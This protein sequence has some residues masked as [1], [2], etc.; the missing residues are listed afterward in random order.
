MTIERLPL[1]N[2]LAETDERVLP[3]A[4][5]LE[6]HQSQ[7]DQEEASL[8][9]EIPVLEMRVAAM[10]RRFQALNFERARRMAHLHEAP[11]PVAPFQ[12]TSEDKY[13]HDN[14]HVSGF[15]NSCKLNN[16]EV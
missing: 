12:E 4:P 11:R 3:S 15:E 7:L 6:A 8:K 14:H 9:A 16:T 13:S 1:R 10:K 2:N 5:V